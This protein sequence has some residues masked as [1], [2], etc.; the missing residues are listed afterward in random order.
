MRKIFI[1]IIFTIFFIS[2]TNA[3]EKK[4]SFS[5]KT[6]Y[7]LYKERVETI[8]DSYKYI[9]NKKENW[10]IRFMI[11]IPD[12]YPKIISKNDDDNQN[13]ATSYSLK[14][15]KNIHI[16]NMNLIYDCAM[17]NINRKSLLL[18]KNDLI[19]S[20]SLSKSMTWIDSEINKTNLYLTTNKCSF[21]S[22]KSS[23]QKLNILAQSTYQTCKYISYLEY[24]KEYNNNYANLLSNNK[25]TNNTEKYSNNEVIKIQNKTINEINNEI[26]NVY[27]IFPLVFHAYN[28]YE[29][30]ITIH[31]LLNLLKYDYN[32]L[33]TQLHKSLNPINQ[34]VYKVSNAMKK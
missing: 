33:R 24:L 22:D 28:D 34:L 25:D 17:L 31:Y 8:C 30:S 6:S 5:L 2:I 27:K 12:N 7:D 4:S 10:K 9:D 11:E 26:Q 13:T 1:Y 29:N 19:K 23:I 20:N 32:L 15:T 3:E 18:I 14:E 16:S 21:S